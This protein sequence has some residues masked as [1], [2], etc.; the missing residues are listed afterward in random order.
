MI[1]LVKGLIIARIGKV[2]SRHETCPD[3]RPSGGIHNASSSSYFGNISDACNFAAADKWEA[4]L[5]DEAISTRTK[6]EEV[7]VKCQTMR[8]FT[9]IPAGDNFFKLFSQSTTLRDSFR[10]CEGML[11]VLGEV[12]YGPIE[13]SW[14]LRPHFSD[15]S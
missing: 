9:Q 7:K 10:Y 12:C 14:E 11:L 1:I 2:K 15:C 4:V 5:P 3:F 13:L 8:V 6:I